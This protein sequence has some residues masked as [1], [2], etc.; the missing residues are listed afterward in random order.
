M[1][2]FA[3]THWLGLWRQVLEKASRG[4]EG[5]A[6]EEGAVGEAQQPTESVS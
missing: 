1:C 5:S 3:A 4:G 6:G 2:G